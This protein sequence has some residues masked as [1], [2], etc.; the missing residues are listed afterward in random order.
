MIYRG[1]PLTDLPQTVQRPANLGVA[2]LAG[3]T[4]YDM[5]DRFTRLL[6]HLVFREKKQAFARVLA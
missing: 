5:Q 1:F 3:L 6:G 2:K 4:T